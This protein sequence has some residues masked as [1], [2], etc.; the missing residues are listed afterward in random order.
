MTWPCDPVDQAEDYMADQTEDDSA[1]EDRE[2][3]EDL[4]W[5][6]AMERDAGLPDLVDERREPGEGEE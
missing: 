5:R 4:K 6:V 2:F 3:W 1:R